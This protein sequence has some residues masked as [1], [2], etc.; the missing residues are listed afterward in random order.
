MKDHRYYDGPCPV[1]VLPQGVCGE[2]LE[3][4]APRLGL[5]GVKL[6]GY[7]T[8]NRAAIR[9]RLHHSTLHKLCREG[10][11]E[12]IKVGKGPSVRTYIVKGAVPKE[13]A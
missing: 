4:Y 7:E 2:D 3:G 5:T 11:L 8:V 1:R 10:K 9:L 12:H 6:A 13:K